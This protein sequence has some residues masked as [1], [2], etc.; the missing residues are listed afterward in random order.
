MSIFNSEMLPFQFEDYS[1]REFKSFIDILLALEV[2]FL[3][4]IITLV[5]RVSNKLAKH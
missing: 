2:T 3:K 1:G 4:A 5:T